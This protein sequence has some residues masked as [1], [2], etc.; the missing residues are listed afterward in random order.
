MKQKGF[1]PLLILVLIG[2]GLLTYF[3]FLY[4]P[5]K[6]PSLPE[7]PTPSSTTTATQTVSSATP[8]Q[9]PTNA[10]TVGPAPARSG[11]HYY[12]KTDKPI[13]SISLTLVYYIPKGL[14]PD[15]NWMS[16]INSNAK[17]LKD[18]YERELNHKASINFYVYPQP[19]LAT[20][21]Y[22]LNIPNTEPD[23]SNGCTQALNTAIGE[24]K[25]KVKPKY[26]GDLTLWAVIFEG[27]NCSV[28]PSNNLIVPGYVIDHF[29]SSGDES[30]AGKLISHE[31]GHL[32]GLPDW[33]ND[34]LSMVHNGKQETYY[35]IM[36][37]GQGDGK[38]HSLNDEFL[39]DTE[40]KGLGL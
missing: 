3:G 7:T 22:N 6:T 19:V 4:H 32:L 38:W 39:S 12:L 35:S 5:T 1:A 27:L 28:G 25:T 34:P 16:G 18:F 11:I 40:K 2:L 37:H 30:L 20:A 21:D 8:S 23:Y 26:S 36:G 17:A 24:I 31:F 33:Y 15:G 10:P 13:D 29:S 14:S 9:N